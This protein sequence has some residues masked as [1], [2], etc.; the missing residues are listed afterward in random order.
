LPEPF[1]PTKK[2]TA[3]GNRR[4]SSRRMA[5]SEYGYPSGTPRG[6]RRRPTSVT[7]S[8]PPVGTVKDAPWCHSE[9][10]TVIT[11]ATRDRKTILDVP[12]VVVL[13]RVFQ[14]GPLTEKTFDW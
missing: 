7:N 11:D 3:V 4:V 1:S 2:V 9:P 13:D 14:S 10:E 12:V 6:S 5:G 8:E